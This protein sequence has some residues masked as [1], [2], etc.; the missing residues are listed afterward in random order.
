MMLRLVLILI[1]VA[2]PGCGTLGALNNA[3]APL[4]TYELSPRA[5]DA[6]FR[7]RGVLLVEAVTAPASLAT[8]RIIVRP[9]GGAVAT[10]PGARWSDSAPAQMR[11]LL[12]R[13]IAAT[14]GFVLVSDGS[15]P[16]PPDLLLLTDLTAFEIVIRDGR[17]V[18]RA[19]ATFALVREADRRVIARRGAGAEFAARSTDPADAIAALDVV[20][21]TLLG[22]AMN[23]VLQNR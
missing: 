8:D 1:L 22:D 19:A 4:P 6:T 9:G 17:P 23:F 16:V 18:A 21:Q 12:V 11:A 7:P 13:S 2:L 10:L 20:T 5:P 15:A 14:E 3:A